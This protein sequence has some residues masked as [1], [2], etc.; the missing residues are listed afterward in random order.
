MTLA[1]EVIEVQMQVPGVR[2][3]VTTR[4]GGCSTGPWAAADGS[5]G[6][7]LGLGS[8]DALENVQRNRDRLAVL[9][10]AS[11]AW[12]SQVHGT[13]VVEA[14]AGATVIEADASTSITPGAVCAVLMAD[15]L[16]VLI[17]SRNGHGVGAAHAGWRGLAGGVIQ[18][19]VQTLRAR[20]E[21]PESELVA[22]L[23]PAIGPDAFEVG[24]EV[25]DA[26]RA[27]LPD[28][29]RAFTPSGE[30]KYRADLF[31]LARMALAQVG[32][33]SVSGGV[34]CTYTDRVRFYSFRRDRVT[35]RQAAFIWI[36]PAH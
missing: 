31:A 14:E 19:T 7:N 26:M 22:Y 11:P 1:R 21:N 5:G 4:R 35:G 13:R 23:G 28:A 6:L 12:L 32:V 15:C 3:L 24:P 2:A 27:R 34:D 36:D 20:L 29:A 33:V 10:P 30:G 17:A 18:N 9:L 16:P 8:G 25:L